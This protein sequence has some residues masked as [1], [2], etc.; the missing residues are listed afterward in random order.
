MRAAPLGAG[1]VRP[2]PGLQHVDGHQA[3]Q[4]RDGRDGLEID[5]RAQAHAADGFHV[6]GAGDARH[7]RAEISGAMIILISRRNSWLNGLKYVRP[8]GMRIAD[9]R[10]GGNADG[11]P[12]EDL[13]RERQAGS[14]GLGRGG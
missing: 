5:H 8:L 13:L 7:Q 11:E 4:Q 1:S 2:T 3:D 12:E 14:S 10:A 6:P 9:E